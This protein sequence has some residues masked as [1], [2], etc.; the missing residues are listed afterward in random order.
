MRSLRLL[1]LL[2]FLAAPTAAQDIAPDIDEESL[3]DLA[4]PKLERLYLHPDAIDPQAMGRAGIEGMEGASARILVLEPKPGELRVRIDEREASFRYDDLGDVHQLQARMD[5]VVAFLLAQE[6]GREDPVTPEDLR[7]QALDG[8]LGT[9]DRHSRLIVGGGLDEFNT[10]FKGT[11]VGIG[12]RIGRRAGHM[13][14]LEPFPDA[15][16]GRAGLLAMDVVTHIDGQSTEAMGVED[17]VDRIRG[18]AGVP[19]VLAVQRDGEVGRRIFLIVREKVLVPSVESERL[20]SDV[21]YIAIDHFSQKTSEEFAEHLAAL[22][23]QGELRGV[24]VDLRGNTGGSLKQSA[25]IVNAFVDHGVLVRTEGWDRK[26]VHKLT[27]RIDAQPDLK[28]FDGPV[29]VLVNRR[30]ASGSEIVAGGLKFLQRSI[31]IGTQ[32][33]GK[34]T[35]QKVYALRRNGRKSSLKMTVA[36]DLLPD[37]AFINSVGVTP[38]VASGQ[39]WLDPDEVTLPDVFHEPAEN[40][41]AAKANGGIDAR[42][43]PGGGRSPSDEGLNGAPVLRLW[44]PRVLPAWSEAA[45]GSAKAEAGSVPDDDGHAGAGE[46][47][48]EADAEATPE[49]A[50]KPPGWANQPGEVGDDLFNDMELRLAWE[51]LEHAPF[52]ARREALLDLAGPIVSEWQTEHTRRMERAALARGLDWSARDTPTWLDR[53][54][55]LATQRRAELASAPPTLTTRLL[56]PDTFRAGEDAVVRLEVTNTTSEPQHHLRARVESSTDILD[57]ASFLIGDLK[58]GQTGGWDLPV[59][60]GQGAVTR[61]D[62][63]RLYLLGEH[64]PLGGPVAGVVFVEGA[65]RPELEL[66]ARTEVSPQADGTVEIVAWVKVRNSGEG[67]TGEVRV[68]FG[69]AGQDDIERKEQFKA[70]GP[71]KPQEAEEAALRLRVRNPAA[72]PTVDIKLRARDGRTGNSTTLAVSLPTTA[73][74]STSGW[75]RPPRVSMTSPRADEPSRGGVGYR[76]QGKVDGASGLDSVTVSVGSDKVFSRSAEHADVAPTSIAFD[77]PAV[78]ERG[79]NAVLVQAESRDGVSVGRRYWVLG[80]D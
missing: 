42:K 1:C 45:P 51:V 37:D 34:G 19:V 22:R 56:L 60:I 65:A 31:T 39:L 52:D 63:Y 61:L 67:D 14:I 59:S 8:V 69:D 57:G 15:P 35:V 5:E 78:L 50:P 33:F 11:L 72:Y 71:L 41:G 58:P 48:D 21:G 46:S 76:V 28:L 75:M 16:A 74:W 13:R 40:L 4:L 77:A 24:V 18:P 49:E 26:P 3:F 38:D 54:P 17:A 32:S 73:A 29:A 55:V 20:P 36:R 6:E 44:Y 10:R 12:A 80:G 47:E 68:R 62:E 7:I 64:G 43:N 2:L 79:P 66:Q 30:T 70:I 53:A 23:A 9:I 27:A 25:R